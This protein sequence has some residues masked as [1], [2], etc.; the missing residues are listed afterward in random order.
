MRI[1]PFSSLWMSFWEVGFKKVK[2]KKDLGVPI[3]KHLQFEEHIIKQCK[4]S[5][6]KT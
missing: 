1:M 4:K 6:T 2:K 5:W 3:N